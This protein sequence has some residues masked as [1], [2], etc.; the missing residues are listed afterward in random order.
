MALTSID[1]HNVWPFPDRQDFS[2]RQ[3]F[4]DLHG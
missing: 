4:P 1:S 2:A 3:D